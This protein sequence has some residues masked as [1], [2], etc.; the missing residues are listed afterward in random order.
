MKKIIEE[1]K[2]EKKNIEMT[3]EEFE[4]LEKSTDKYI[5]NN[6]RLKRYLFI[7]GFCYTEVTIKENKYNCFVFDK[8]K[9]LEE[10]I[11]FFVHIRNINHNQEQEKNRQEV[12][13]MIEKIDF[14]KED[15]NVLR[16]FIKV[17][18]R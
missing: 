2:N 16:Q 3:M 7:L 6:L 9:E 18:D 13:K 12:K 10:S 5:T 15:L 17:L 11:K 4:E 1:E 8:T 14:K